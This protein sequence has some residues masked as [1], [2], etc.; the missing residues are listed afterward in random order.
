MF[1]FSLKKDI[2]YTHAGEYFSKLLFLD[3]SV[4]E[5]SSLVHIVEGPDIQKK[6]THVAKE[7]GISYTLI[8]SYHDILSIATS[9]R[10]IFSIVAA[11]CDTLLCPQLLQTKLQIS[12]GDQIFLEDMLRQLQ[13]LSYEFHEYEKAGSYTRKGDIMR[14]ILPDDRV[15][16]INFWG[17][18]IESIILEGVNIHTFDFYSLAKLGTGKKPSLPLKE[19]F[20]TQKVWCVLDMLEF[21][22]LFEAFS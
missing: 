16:V 1:P 15:C 13:D 11:S 14:V 7:L 19:L 3:A 8:E 12:V 2:H 17:N 6:Y 20:K 4:K 9:T 5:E 10:G 18:E 22:P 21:H